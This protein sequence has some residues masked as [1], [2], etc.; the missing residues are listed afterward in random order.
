M[1]LDP[2]FDVL[3]RVFRRL[4]LGVAL[5]SHVEKCA[6]ARCGV[7]YALDRVRA[8]RVAVVSLMPFRITRVMTGMIR[9]LARKRHGRL[10]SLT[11]LFRKT[12]DTALIPHQ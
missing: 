2:S 1:R 11:L 8:S 10:R 5:I 9:R 3:S 4:A 12:D 7:Q 6:A